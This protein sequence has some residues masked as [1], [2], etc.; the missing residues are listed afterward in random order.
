MT[1][2]TSDTND[3]NDTLG[4][5]WNTEPF[6]PGT[7]FECFGKIPGTSL[8]GLYFRFSGTSFSAPFVAGTAAL[9]RSMLPEASAPVVEVILRRFSDDLGDPGYD[10]EFGHGRSNTGRILKALDG[11]LF[12][13]DDFESGDLRAWSSVV[14]GAGLLF[15][16]LLRSQRLTDTTR[17]FSAYCW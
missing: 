16:R 14:G 17:F 3:V 9:I 12:F 5:C 7:S 2:R 11:G 6:P 10:I 1:D 4:Y 15:R 13:A 8:G